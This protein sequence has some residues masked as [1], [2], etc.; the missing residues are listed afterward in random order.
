MSETRIFFKSGHGGEQPNIVVPLSFSQVY[1][2]FKRGQWLQVQL[3][4]V[5]VG[6]NPDQVVTIAGDG[7][8]ERSEG[9]EVVSTF[10]GCT[11]VTHNEVDCSH[12]PVSSQCQACLKVPETP[13]PLIMGKFVE[14]T[15]AERNNRVVEFYA[16]EA[17]QRSAEGLVSLADKQG[18]LDGERVTQRAYE[19]LLNLRRALHDLESLADRSNA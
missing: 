5:W 7:E 10:T 17:L 11:N 14:G 2:K 12:L 8:Q 16:W 15:P 6:I 19:S 18:T 9:A 1:D 13:I 3:D 4:G